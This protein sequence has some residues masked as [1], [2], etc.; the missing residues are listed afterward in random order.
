MAYIKPKM[1]V[2]FGNNGKAVQAVVDKIAFR[3]YWAKPY[4]DKKTGKWVPYFCKQF[5]SEGKCDKKKSGC[6]YPHMTVA[7]R[8]AEE[9]KKNAEKPE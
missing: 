1:S 4:K 3:K 8:D 5:L 2:F 6:K 7:Q 9:R